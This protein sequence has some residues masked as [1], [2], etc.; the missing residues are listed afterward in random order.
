[1]WRTGRRRR[2]PRAEA[3]VGDISDYGTI[4][5]TVSSP[6]R[7]QGGEAADSQMRSS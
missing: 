7:S 4:V 1:M 2:S 3:I 6:L 5:A